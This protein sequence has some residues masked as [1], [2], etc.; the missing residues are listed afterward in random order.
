[1]SLK[2]G[3][4]VK[5]CGDPTLT[6]N[7]N[8]TGY[9]TFIKKDTVG[10]QWTSGTYTEDKK[11]HLKKISSAKFKVGDK[12]TYVSDSSCT[13]IIQWLVGDNVGIK[14]DDG[15]QC[16]EKTCNIVL[17]KNLNLS[18]TQKQQET[19][20]E[21]QK[22]KKKMKRKIQDLYDEDRNCDKQIEEL[23]KRK[24]EIQERK[25]EIQEK[26]KSAKINLVN[27]KKIKW[28][29]MPIEQWLRDD[30]IVRKENEFHIYETDKEKF[31]GVWCGQNKLN[32]SDSEHFEEFVHD[33]HF[34]GAPYYV[35]RQLL[36]NEPSKATGCEA[37]FT[38][39]YKLMRLVRRTDG[40]GMK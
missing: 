13:G 40:F 12:V 9:V 4:K 31:M 26:I 15:L 19:Q 3:D 6:D 10:V 1:M 39:N 7:Y 37:A 23:L 33:Y 18:Y 34:Y 27:E 16:Q 36:K 8:E 28:V 38:K 32:K 24:K 29:E 30:G 2:V 25:K 21:S 20:K 11:K 17:K 22:K 35:D 5:F 14:W